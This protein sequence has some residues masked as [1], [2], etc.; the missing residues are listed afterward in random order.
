MKALIGGKVRFMITGGAPI[1]GEVLEFLKVVFS[2][3]IIEGYG[4]TETA[5]G[6]TLTD[7][8]DPQCGHVGSIS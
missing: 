1:S 2:C 6:F 3:A 4:L 8:T 7:K 5:G